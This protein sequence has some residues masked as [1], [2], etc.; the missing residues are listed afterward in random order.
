MLYEVIT[1]I[2]FQGGV[3]QQE[4]V[5]KMRGIHASCAD[6]L[7]ELLVRADLVAA[8]DLDDDASYNFV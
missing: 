6:F 3:A 7:H 5:G 2:S 8:D 4:L 1:D